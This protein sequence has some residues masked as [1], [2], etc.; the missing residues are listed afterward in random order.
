MP[1]QTSNIAAYHGV[2]PQIATS[3][4]IHFRCAFDTNV[5]TKLKTIMIL[6]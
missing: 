1:S 4:Y 2:F 6:T 3:A 5:L